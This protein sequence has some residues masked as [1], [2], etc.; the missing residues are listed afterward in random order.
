MLVTL[1][2]HPTLL[3]EPCA[4]Q[5]RDEKVMEYHQVR[6]SALEPPGDL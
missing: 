3:L 2:L 1:S 4:N 6:T 5:A